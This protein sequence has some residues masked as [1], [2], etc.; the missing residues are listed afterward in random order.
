[1]SERDPFSQPPGKESNP[2]QLP[3]LPVA[4]EPLPGGGRLIALRTEVAEYDRNGTQVWVMRRPGS[5]VLTARRAPN[6]ETLVLT[7]KQNNPNNLIRL[8][9]KGVEVGKVPV[10]P[11]TD[12]GHLD[13]LPDGRVLVSETARVAE[14]DLKTGKD[15][16]QYEVQQPTCAQRLSNGN[17]LVTTNGRT[18]A[19]TAADGRRVTEVDPSGEVVWE[20]RPADNFSILR[21]Y[22]R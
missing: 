7:R 19:T 14:Y 15:V 5:D 11:T 4:A 20:Y 1:V 9:A 16:W 18:R 13:P 10:G 2:R 21:A 22:R 6:G 12:H 17:T 3:N 8:D